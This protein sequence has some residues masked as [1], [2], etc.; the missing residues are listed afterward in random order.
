[1]PLPER[2]TFQLLFTVTFSGKLTVTVQPLTCVAPLLV[3]V[4]STWKKLPPVLDGV[5]VQV[6]AASA[7]P[8]S[9]RLD[10]NIPS[11][12]NVFIINPLQ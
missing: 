11:F 3:T 10:S 5:A 1:V 2:V 9:I 6:Y 8:P 7:C 12:K 4:T